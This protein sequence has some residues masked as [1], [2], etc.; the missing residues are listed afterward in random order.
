MSP[1]LFNMALEEA[2]Q[3]VSNSETG[4]KIGQKINILAFADGVIIIAHIEE[5]LKDLIIILIEKIGKFGLKINKKYIY[6]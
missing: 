1:I 5:E 3:K 2:L 6:K 4:I